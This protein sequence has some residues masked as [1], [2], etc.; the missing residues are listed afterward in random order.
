VKQP[1]FSGPSGRKPGR[2]QYVKAD[3][4]PVVGEWIEFAEH[5]G[6]RHKILAVKDNKALI[7]TAARG[8]HWVDISPRNRQLMTTEEI[9]TA[10]ATYLARLGG[11]KDALKTERLPMTK[12]AVDSSGDSYGHLVTAT[13]QYQEELLRLKR[14][15]AH[16]E[17]ELARAR[18][19]NRRAHEWSISR[20]NYEMDLAHVRRAVSQGLTLERPQGSSYHHMQDF[21]RQCV[22]KVGG[23]DGWWDE[24]FQ[25]FV[26][27]SDWARALATGG[28]DED[29]DFPMPYDFTCFELRVSGMRVLLLMGR[30]AGMLVIGINK[31]W[32]INSNV[33]G[34]VQGRLVTLER[35]PGGLDLDHQ[36]M[37]DM[38][39]LVGDQVRAVCIALDEKRVFEQVT[40]QVGGGLNKQR[41]ARGLSEVRDYHVVRLKP[42]A[43]AR[44][45]PV[46]G[47]VRGPLQTWHRRRG[48]WRHY[49]LPS[50]GDEQYMDDD[51]TLRSRTWINWMFVGNMDGRFIDKEYRL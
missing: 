48:H 33:L 11:F 19:K 17:R 39:K 12:H 50:S 2:R 41:R 18:I 38:L 43:A 46:G 47:Y 24:D 10:D 3:E 35:Q 42:R 34:F 21:L 40:V 15:R 1:V 4:Q 51:G 14:D 26:V 25:S 23:K 5:P 32:Y 9:M 29:G 16:S 44:V 20:E 28:G 37:S 22:A 49:D 6:E 30:D 7:N 27:E 13:T 31:R 8:D 45:E 36:L